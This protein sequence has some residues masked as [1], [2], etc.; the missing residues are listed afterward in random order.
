M[1]WSRRL[2]RWAS[3][4]LDLAFPRGEERTFETPD[5]NTRQATWNDVLLLIGKLEKHGAEYVLIG[6]YA[7]AFNGLVRQTGDVDILVRN[8]PENNRRWIAALCELPA[9]AAKDLVSTAEDPFPREEETG[10]EYAEP[11]VI[12]VADEFIVDVM[13]KACG[14]TY[15]D[16]RPFMHRESHN[17]NPINVLDLHG[18]RA[19]KQ[20]TRAR[21]IEDLRHIEAAIAAL[22]DEVSGHVRTMAR[23][24]LA[25]EPKPPERGIEAR[26]D[27]PGPSEEAL[28]MASEIV[29]RAG[30]EGDISGISAETLAIYADEEVL[31]KVLDR[32]EPIADLDGLLRRLGVDLPR[33]TI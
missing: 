18:L 11:G 4:L 5:G 6:G 13:P 19:T 16:L 22:K 7:L 10:D 30:R 2:G 21:D 1:E 14:L 15:D 23:R 20:T 9:G 28:Q 25:S 24:P 31:R 8:S 32:Q 27:A 12:R 33:Y 26:V 29:E 17:G 3:R